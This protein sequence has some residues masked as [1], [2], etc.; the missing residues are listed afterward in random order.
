MEQELEQIRKDGVTF[1]NTVSD[2]NQL[3]TFRVDY[4]GRNGRISSIMKQLGSVGKEDRPR[5]GQ[6]ANSIKKRA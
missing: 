2:D 6:L 3:E 5:F 4:L 1:L